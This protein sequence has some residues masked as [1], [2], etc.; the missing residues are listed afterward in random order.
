LS[1]SLQHSLIGQKNVAVVRRALL[2]ERSRANA[3]PDSDNINA[4]WAR[5]SLPVMRSHEAAVILKF[6]RIMQ[7]VLPVGEKFPPERSLLRMQKK[8]TNIF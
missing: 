6:H 5:L 4:L 3:D 7:L 8:G 2:V 1:G